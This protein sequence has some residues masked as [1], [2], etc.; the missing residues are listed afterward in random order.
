VDRCDCDLHEEDHHA[1]L[2]VAAAAGLALGVAGVVWYMR[3]RDPVRSMDRLLRRCQDRITG[4]E[5]SLTDLEGAVA[6]A[7]SG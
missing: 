6:T 4:I 5:C 3:Y 7:G 1:W 2:W